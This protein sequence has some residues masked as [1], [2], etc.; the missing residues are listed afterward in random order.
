MTNHLPFDRRGFLKLVACAPAALLGQ[1]PA[2]GETL[3]PWSPGTLDI[4]HISTGRGS[5]TFLLLPD[6]TTLLID[7]GDVQP[8]PETAKFII[9]PK[10]DA[11]RRPGEWI[12][13][14]ILRQMRPAGRAELDYFLLTHFHNDHMSGI[15]DVAAA[16]PV[17]RAIDR[18]YPSYDYPAALDDVHQRKYRAFVASL[19]ERGGK[20][21]RFRPGAADQIR[22]LREPGKYAGFAVRNLV[23]NGEVWTGIGD[24]TRRHFPELKYLAPAEYPTE[25]MCSLGIRLSYGRFDYFSAGDMSFDTNAGRDPWRDIET[26][27][28]QAAGP[29]DVAVANHHGWMDATG[30]GFVAALRPRAFIINAWD[31]A[32]PAMPATW[33]MLSTALYP[34]E[35]GIY[36]TAMKA[37]NKIAN[38]RLAEL[39]SE[40]GHVVVRVEPPGDR[41]SIFIVSNEDES[42]RVTARFGSFLA[43]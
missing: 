21:E 39:K 9:D 4:H 27:V 25:N 18:A 6:G 22:L 11:S 16:V 24:S 33:A 1:A 19:P 31:S 2:A 37:E 38:R 41:Y 32:H 13:R 5:C 42:G 35:R 10:P 36:A 12:A 43:N 26:P 14:Y 34:G 3:A 8:P 23:A 29:V 15:M 40:N 7:A 30:P 20:A 17:R 28:A